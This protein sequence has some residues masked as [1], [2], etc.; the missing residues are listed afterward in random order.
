MNGHLARLTFVFAA[1][2]ASVAIAGCS[3]TGSSTDLPRT[4]SAGQPAVRRPNACPCFTVLY[5][6][7]DSPHTTNDGGQP[8]GG[9]AYVGGALYGTT[10]QGSTNNDGTVF[11][12]TH[13]STGW[14]ETIIHIFGANGDGAHP[15]ADLT[16][17]AADGKVYGTTTLGG[18]YG[19]GIA[20]YVDTTTD[21]Y[22]VFYNFGR[23]GSGQQSFG[24]LYP[25]ASGSFFGTT[26]YGGSHGAGTLFT[27]TTA[28]SESIIYSFLTVAGEG[29]QPNGNLYRS[30]G[31]IYGTTEG[32]GAHSH[33]TVYYYSFGTQKMTVLY[34]FMSGTDGDTPHSGLN[35]F[36]N[37]YYGTTR[38]GGDNSN[39]GTIYKVAQNGTESVLHRF[40]GTDG[41]R[42]LAA[43]TNPLCP[44]SASSCTLYG[45]TIAGGANSQGVLFSIG[46]DG[47]YHDLHDLSGTDGAT[48][49]A[50][51][52]WVPATSTLYGTASY[53]GKHG[54]GTVFSFKP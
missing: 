47:T 3:R 17:V 34:S 43:L 15:V 16:Y 10:Y 30:P 24:G 20:F 39:D 25:G 45:S 44:S 31:F 33:G 22:H 8:E 35:A 36:N 18:L 28:G 51:M 13:G 1:M 46:L 29:D 14:K 48:P 4:P 52:I 7:G 11:K 26:A 12:L 49:V 53:Q 27:L 23:S 32:G 37:V 6:F 42:P 21:M 5:N 38:Y 40:S 54:Q 50:D 2:A 19:K 41:S 9:M